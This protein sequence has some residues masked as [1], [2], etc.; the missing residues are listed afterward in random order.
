MRLGD[1]AIASNGV[2]YLGGAASASIY[3]RD[4]LTLNGQPVGV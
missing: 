3:N 1:I 2:L 4:S